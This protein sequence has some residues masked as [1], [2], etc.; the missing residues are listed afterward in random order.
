[1]VVEWRTSVVDGHSNFGGD[2]DDEPSPSIHLVRRELERQVAEQ[3]SRGTNFD[4]KSGL[5]LALGGALIGLTQDSSSAY[6]I[7]SLL[8]ASAA[9]LAAVSAMFPRI[10]TAIKPG[11]LRDRY[12]MGDPAETELTLLDTRIFLYEQDEER[13]SAKV[14]RMKVTVILLAISVFLMVAATIT[15]STTK[16]T[17]DGTGHPSSGVTSRATSTTGRP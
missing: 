4:T 15:A 5:L 12:L 2:G 16:E 13:L 11:S 17:S 7:A 8:F 9:V 14:L 10:A 1:V 6:H 3:E